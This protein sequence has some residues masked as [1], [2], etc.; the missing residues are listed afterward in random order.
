[1][2]EQKAKAI[3]SDFIV[4][5]LSKITVKSGSCRYNYK[6]QMNTVHDALN[7]DEDKIAICFYYDGDCPIIHFIN[8]DKQGNYIDNTLG[9]W[10]ETFEYYLI[11]TIEKESF[12]DINNIF[13]AY[14]TEIKNKIPFYIKWFVNYEF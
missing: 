6:C 14:R 11:R 10:S 9:R 8:I 3:I 12:F 13:W 2:F 1:M 5:N 7:N 4:A